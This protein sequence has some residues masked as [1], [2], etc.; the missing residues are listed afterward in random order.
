MT[1]HAGIRT[2]AARPAR[3]DALALAERTLRD[4]ERLDM[5][6]LAG[7]L[8]IGRATL[9]RW[10]GSRDQLLGEVLWRMSEPIW[11]E[12]QAT[13][14][15]TGAERVAD[16]LRRYVERVAASEPLRHLLDAE[17]E[18]A[19]RILMTSDGPIQERTVGAVEDL[20]RAESQ[21]GA[22]LPDVDPHQ[23][24]FAIVRMGESFLYADVVAAREPDTETAAAVIR[25]LL[26]LQP[27]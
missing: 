14:I 5:R 11:A 1:D 25:L 18:T 10:T 7:E 3:R 4:G 9:Y 16:V 23:L 12:C 22:S 19:L 17:P 13:A 15:G 6:A 26:G 21:D 27:R 20:L 24:A 8:G 2:A